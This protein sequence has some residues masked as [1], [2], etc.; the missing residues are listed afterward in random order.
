MNWQEF[1]DN[2]PH[3]KPNRT[4]V[5]TCEIKFELDK[6]SAWLGNCEKESCWKFEDSQKSAVDVLLD[7]RERNESI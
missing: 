5:D 3:R 7:A 4:D 6:R 2:C 1:R